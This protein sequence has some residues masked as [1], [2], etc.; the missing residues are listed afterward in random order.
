[1]ERVSLPIIK[2]DEKLSKGEVETQMLD[3]N[4]ILDLQSVSYS[5]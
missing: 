3:G 4:S 5:S 2:E 1:M